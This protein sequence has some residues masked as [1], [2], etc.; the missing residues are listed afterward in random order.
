M[1]EHQGLQIRPPKIYRGITSI[2]QKMDQTER[3]KAPE[4]AQTWQKKEKNGAQRANKPTQ[5]QGRHINI[6]QFESKR[7]KLLKN[8]CSTQETPK[9]MMNLKERDKTVKQWF[10]SVNTKQENK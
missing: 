1:Y 4:K 9:E 10:L 7:K 3:T 6:I 2:Y 5:Q 8:A